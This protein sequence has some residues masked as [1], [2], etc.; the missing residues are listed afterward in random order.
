MSFLYRKVLFDNTLRNQ[1][2]NLKDL[3][4]KWITIKPNS[5]KTIGRIISRDDYLK[6]TGQYN[7]GF[8]GA[9]VGADVP[10]MGDILQ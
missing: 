2:P 9:E 4:N 3:M 1:I 7:G 10:S 8:Q 5:Y 6:L